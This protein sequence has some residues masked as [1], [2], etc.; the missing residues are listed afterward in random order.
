MACYSIVGMV[1]LKL[2]MPH[3]YGH[4]YIM[5]KD[6]KGLFCGSTYRDLRYTISSVFNFGSFITLVA[7]YLA[8]CPEQK[9]R[10][11]QAELFLRVGR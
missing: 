10:I 4:V 6:T 5:Y 8:I 3:F 2:F 9:C 1:L 7:R 11:I